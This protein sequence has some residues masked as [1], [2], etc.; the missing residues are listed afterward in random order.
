[1]ERLVLGLPSEFG[2]GAVVAA[3]VGLAGDAQVLFGGGVGV[4]VGEDGGIGDVFHQSG[5]EDRSGNA[6]DDVVQRIHLFEVGLREGAG[7][8]LA[9][10]AGSVGGVHAAGDGEQVVDA[11]VG[12]AGEF[13]VRADDE[14]EAGLAHRPIGLDEVGKG[15]GGAVQ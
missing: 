9:G 15:V 8:E 13:A 12:R 1:F 2:D 11:A 3:A 6:E 5:A 10:G 4:H 7:L 14:D